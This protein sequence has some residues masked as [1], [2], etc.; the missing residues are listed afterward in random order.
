MYGTLGTQSCPLENPRHTKQSLQQGREFMLG[1]QEQ[2][3]AGH[4]RG[5]EQEPGGREG[6]K[7]TFR[8]KG[9]DWSFQQAGAEAHGNGGGRKWGERDQG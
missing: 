5:T 8:A 1:T 6:E 4:R 3:W 7:E 2:P 9:Q